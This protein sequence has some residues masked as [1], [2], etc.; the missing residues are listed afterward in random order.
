MVR[1]RH[2]IKWDTIKRIVLKCFFPFSSSCIEDVGP[3]RT[4]KAHGE[5]EEYDTL[6]DLQELTVYQAFVT[7]RSNCLRVNRNRREGSKQSGKVSSG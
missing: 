5:K 1:A 4:F 3:S 2:I 6:L 7:E